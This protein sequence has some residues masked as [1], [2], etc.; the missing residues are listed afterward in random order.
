[1]ID[2]FENNKTTNDSVVSMLPDT[3]RA[4]IIHPAGTWKTVIVLRLCEN[5]LGKI[6]C[7]LSLRIY[8]KKT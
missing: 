3:G 8:S 1:M 7:W 6:V 5:H 2:F 4:A